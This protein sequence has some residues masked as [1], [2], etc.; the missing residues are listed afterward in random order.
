MDGQNRGDIKPG[1]E[2][3]IVL[4]QDQ[5]TGKLTRGIV[6]NILTSSPHHHRG[7]KVRLKDG[8]VGRVQRI[9]AD[10]S[11]NVLEQ[12]AITA[13][14]FRVAVEQGHGVKLGYD[15]ESII[16]LYRLLV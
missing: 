3:D 4:K 7:I 9:L 10:S 12:I 8:R 14:T 6:A 15:G 16:K 11:D 5:P 1:M 13:E 2:V